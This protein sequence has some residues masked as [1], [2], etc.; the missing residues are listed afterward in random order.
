MAL[1]RHCLS[2]GSHKGED[3][4]KKAL[5][6]LAGFSYLVLY[7]IFVSTASVAGK[8]GFQSDISPLELLTFRLILAAAA[9]WIYFLCFKRDALRLDR[10]GLI[11]CMQVAALNSVSMLTYFSG[12][13][14][15]DASLSIVIYMTGFI[16][17]VMLMLMIRGEYPST[18]WR[19]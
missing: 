14:Y 6:K 9:L 5:A 17:A 3:K 11:G 7:S 4:L 13:L 8:V 15:L 16:P 10:V 2:K 1:G 18:A 19:K 12:L